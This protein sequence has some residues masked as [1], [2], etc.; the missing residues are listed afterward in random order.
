[1]LTEPGVKT[2]L[3]AMEL[4]AGEDAD[5]LF[6][7]LD[8]ENGQV[9]ADALIKGMARLKGSARSIDMISLMHEVKQLQEQLLAVKTAGVDSCCAGSVAAAQDGAQS[10]PLSP[11]YVQGVP[12]RSFCW[13]DSSDGEFAV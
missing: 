6:S 2:W 4:D 8:K 9:S 13:S 12:S 5:N 10:H 3:A 1:V 7:L 11:S